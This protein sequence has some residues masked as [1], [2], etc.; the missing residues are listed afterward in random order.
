MAMD[1]AAYFCR[2]RYSGERAPTSQVL[3]ELQL[4]H[5][6]SVPFENLD[7]HLGRPI[8]LR[9]DVLFH[10]VVVDGRGGFC[11]ELNALFAWLLRQLGFQV[12]YLSARDAH[13]DG[14]LGPEFDHLA[15]Q[16]NIPARA[17]APPGHAG[18]PEADHLGW[19]ADVGWGDTFRE[20]LT[21][22]PEMLQ[23]Q[24]DRAFRLEA[25]EQ[26]YL[27]WQRKENGRWKRDFQFSLQPRRISEFLPMCEF[28][29]SSHQSRWTQERLCTIATPGGR[30]TLRDGHLRLTQGRRE[31]EREVG[32][33]TEYST[34][35]RWHS[36]GAAAL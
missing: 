6:L 21:L 25:C 1:I 30:V 8:S 3:R 26:G 35:L 17:D 4:A 32:D 36:F 15:L 14:G 9:E 2:I 12:T 22:A 27:L 11:Y 13:E 33:P 29:Q 24:G 10:K 16:V 18:A 28:Q 31:T 34:A 5:L 20:P 19:L 23:V 7:I